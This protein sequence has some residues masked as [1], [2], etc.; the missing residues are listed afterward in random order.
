MT[1]NIEFVSLEY[2]LFKNQEIDLCNANWI[3][4]ASDADA[5]SCVADGTY[6]FSIPYTLPDYED[7]ASW[8]ATGWRGTGFMKMFSDSSSSDEKMIGFCTFKLSTMVT[9]KGDGSFTP[10][11]AAMTIGIV[12]GVIAL[13]ALICLY[14]TCCRR[15]SKVVTTKSSEAGKTIASD[16]ESQ[17]ASTASFTKMEDDGT[18]ET[19]NCISIGGNSGSIGGKSGSIGGKSG[20]VAKSKGK[21]RFFFPP[22]C[23]T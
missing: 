11:T 15:S 4:P 7:N 16:A 22:K 14:C 6:G 21:R 10:P 18:L 1:A 20:S 5:D 13:S 12:A 17:R 19:S 8:L 9:S 3:T 2:L 23:D